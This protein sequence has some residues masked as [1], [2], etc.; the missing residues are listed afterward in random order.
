MD[1]LLIELPLTHIRGFREQLG[2]SFL[3]RN[4]LTRCLFRMH[5]TFLKSFNSPKDYVDVSSTF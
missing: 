5:F 4:G 3:P 1:H 2:F